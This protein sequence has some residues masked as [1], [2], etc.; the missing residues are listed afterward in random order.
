MV[1]RRFAK[2]RGLAPH[3]GSTPS[4][5]F[6]SGLAERIKAAVPKTAGR[7]AAPRVRISHPLPFP[8]TR[9]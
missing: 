4:P 7:F 5:S 2:A 6:F 9:G 1:R 8:L 3:G